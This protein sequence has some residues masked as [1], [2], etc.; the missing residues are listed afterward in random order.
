MT[1]EQTQEDRHV[2][3]LSIVVTTYDIEAYVGLLTR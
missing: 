1:T 2:P 3:R